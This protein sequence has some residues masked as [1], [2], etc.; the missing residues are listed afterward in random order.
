M[1]KTEMTTGIFKGLFSIFINRTDESTGADLR[2]E[3]HWN[4]SNI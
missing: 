4:S 3:I 1:L 2:M